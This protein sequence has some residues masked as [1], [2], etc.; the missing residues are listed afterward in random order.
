MEEEVEVRLENQRTSGSHPGDD[1]NEEGCSKSGTWLNLTLG[2]NTSSAASSSS[3]QSGPTSHKVFS[4]NFCM[5][6]FFSSQ[7]LGGHQNAHKR[8]RGAAR[9]SNQ[10]QRMV[11]GLPLNTPFLHSLG[12]HPHS[13]IQKP[14]RDGGM[15]TVA[16]FDE[17]SSNAKMAW[18]PFSLDEGMDLRW[19]R[20]F[21]NNSQRPKQSSEH[22]K[23]DLNLRL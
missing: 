19:S 15:A 8:E 21:R 14:Q 12:V 5:R 16:R 4:C 11:V 7:A 20:S 1:S 22:Q 3:S 18:A 17:L 10:A 2:V 6:K 23:I 13:V 9:R